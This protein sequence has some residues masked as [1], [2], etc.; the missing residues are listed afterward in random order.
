[1][2]GSRPKVT[3]KLDCLVFVLP[4]RSATDSNFCGS[5]ISALF[6]ATQIKAKVKA[7]E[8]ATKGEGK[9]STSTAEPVPNQA[10]RNTSLSGT[11]RQHVVA[12][13]KNI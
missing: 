10:K 2:H 7:K 11:L 3:H 8:S 5:L 13:V 9:Q 6:G 4:H 12:E 1:M